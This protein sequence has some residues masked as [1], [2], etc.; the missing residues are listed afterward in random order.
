MS[1]RE[2]LDADMRTAMK[3][4]DKARLSV[5]RMLRSKMQEAEVAGRGKEGPDYALYEEAAL[6]AVAS[7]AKQRRES[8]DSYREAGREELAAAEE[9]ELKIVTEY[10]PEQLSDDEVRGLVQDAVAEAGATSPKDMGAVMK[11]VMP[12]VRG[13]ADGK[14][15]NRI[16][17]ECL[18]PRDG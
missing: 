9:A 17:R 4:G 1:T 10:L 16:V 7:Y 15:V 18:T 2:R 13:R 3:A 6:Q 14:L 5:I 8:I 12:Q 11:L